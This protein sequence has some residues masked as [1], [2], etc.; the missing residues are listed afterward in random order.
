MSGTSFRPSYGGPAYSV[1]RLASALA[2]LGLDVGLWAPDRS[3]ALLDLRAVHKSVMRL[4]GDFES[5]SAT[6]GRPDLLHDNGIWMPHNHAIARWAA[7]MSVPRLVSLRGMLEPWARAYKK[8]KKD[9]AWWAYQKRDLASADRLHVT[10]E[11]ERANAL[12]YGLRTAIVFIPNGVDVPTL[13]RGDIEACASVK[14]AESR[15]ALY[16]GRIHPQ[17][18]LLLLV[19]AWGRVRPP[20]W[21]LRIVGPDETGHA[22]DLVRTIKDLS[23][24]D[25]I[26]VEGVIT[27]AEERKRT[28]FNSELV[29]LPSYAES[30]GIAVAEA[31]AHTVPV[32]TTTGTPWAGLQSNDCGWWVD[33]NVDAIAAALTAATSKGR[34]TLLE[35]GL[36][37]KHWISDECSWGNISPKFVEVYRAIIAS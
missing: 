30:F 22:A 13:S 20:H 1:A 17:K 35:M 26:S 3:P 18:G 32:I 31:L 27:D 6:F 12:R 7:R 5:A 8:W 21:T 2:E 29:I 15:I 10:S 33:P 24:E 34:K 28:Y 11:A 25:V 9:I 19:K 14:P 16:L 23:L 37:G 4:D 36:R